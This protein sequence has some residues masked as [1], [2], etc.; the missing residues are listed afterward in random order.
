MANTSLIKLRPE[1]LSRFPLVGRFATNALLRRFDS[2]RACRR[3]SGSHLLGSTIQ[4]LPRALIKSNNKAKTKNKLKA[5]VIHPQKYCT[6]SKPSISNSNNN[7]QNYDCHNQTLSTR[8]QHPH[9]LPSI[10]NSNSSSRRYTMWYTCKYRI[11]FYILE[12]IT[13][14]NIWN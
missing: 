8:Q 2:V 10:I 3:R 14:C 1:S 5:A 13:R 6:P 7:H 12:Y 9:R 4:K 11:R